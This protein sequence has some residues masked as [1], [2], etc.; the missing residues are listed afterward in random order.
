MKIKDYVKDLRISVNDYMQS[1][2]KYRL[3]ESY[4]KKHSR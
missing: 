3:S 2:Y 4:G 1:N